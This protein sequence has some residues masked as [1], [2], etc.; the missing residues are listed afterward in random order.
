MI[1]QALKEYYDR[2]P[3]LPRIG[4]ELKDIP[5]VIVLDDDGVPVGLNETAEGQG[6][7]RRAKSFLVPQAVKR[8]VGI[9]ANTLWDNPE[10]V[11]GVSLKGDAERA[12]EQHAAFQRNIA[13]LGDIPDAG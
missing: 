12:A 1:L 2:K 10:Y 8:S 7:A 5:F 11:L 13:H 4:F 9:V 6:R 3:E